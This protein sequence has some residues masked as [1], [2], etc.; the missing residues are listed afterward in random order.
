[1]GPM[2]AGMPALHIQL[3]SSLHYIRYLPEDVERVLHARQ[4][5]AVPHAATEG[6]RSEGGNRFSAGRQGKVISEV[7]R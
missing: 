6:G 5:R 7:V 1:M 3:R 4:P 2:S